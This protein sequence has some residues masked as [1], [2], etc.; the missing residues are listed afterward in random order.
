MHYAAI[1][2][3]ISSKYSA[4]NINQRI[5]WRTFT[6][7]GNNPKCTS[8]SSM[9]RSKGNDALF[10]PYTLDHDGCNCKSARCY[11]KSGFG[12][13]HGHFGPLDRVDANYEI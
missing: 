7:L 6:R 9:S 2:V 5:L 11:I 13:V 1:H 4:Q 3:E 10:A 12:H 8:E